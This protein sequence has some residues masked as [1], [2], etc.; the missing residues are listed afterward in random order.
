MGWGESGRKGEAR[1]SRVEPCTSTQREGKRR[2]RKTSSLSWGMARK[3]VGVGAVFSGLSVKS[4]P[5]PCGNPA[6]K[7]PTRR[8]RT[9]T[10]RFRRQSQLSKRKPEGL[11]LCLWVDPER[12]LRAAINK[13]PTVSLNK[14]ILRCTQRMYLFV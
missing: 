3:K 14:S 4:E 12:L 8:S 7:P 9:H 11:D 6:E 10:R 1:G 5:A 2:R 13:D